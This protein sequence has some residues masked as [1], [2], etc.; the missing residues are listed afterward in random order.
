M[1]A[2]AVVTVTLSLRANDEKPLSV[3]GKP[4]WW[5]QTRVGPGN[6]EGRAIRFAEQTIPRNAHIG[7]AIHS[8]DWSYPFFGPKL[9][10]TV[11]FV[12]DGGPV[13]SDLGWLVVA[14]D[15]RVPSGQWR[16]ALTTDDGWRVLA[17]TRP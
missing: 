11:R 4:R 3:W 2:I 9:E 12:R 6:G 1:L 16:T 17:K 8:V 15:K 14:P 13:G 10:R 7:L 5:V